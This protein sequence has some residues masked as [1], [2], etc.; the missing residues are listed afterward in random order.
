MKKFISYLTAII[1]VLQIISGISVFASG[2]TVKSAIVY[3]N[4]ATV[5]L[6]AE[7]GMNFNVYAASYNDDGMLTA[8]TYEN[9]TMTESTKTVTLDNVEDNVKI[10]VWDEN[11]AP[12]CKTAKSE[13]LNGIIYLNNTSI[14]ADGVTGATVDGTTVTITEAGN[15]KIVGTLDDG[16]IVISSSAKSDKIKL[17]LDN[18]SVTSTTGNALN[19]LKGKVTIVNSGESTFTAQADSTDAIYSKNDLTVKGEGTLNAVSELGNGIRCKADLEIGSGDINVTAYNNGIKGDEGIKITK[20]ASEI[21]VTAQTGDALK[22]DA[23]DPD[24]LELEYGKGNITINGGTLN[25]TATAGDGI[26]A[27]DTVTIAGGDITINSA[28]DGIKANTV[29]TP[30]TDETGTT[31]YVEGNVFINGGTVDITASEDGI[32]ASGSVNISDGDI[33]VVSMLDGIQSGV[34]YT[35]A[36]NETQYSQGDL[37]ISGGTLDI[38]AGGGSGANRNDDLSH[39]GV[40]ALNE[41]VIT[42]GTFDINSYDDAIHSNMITTIA[43]GTFEISSGDDGIHADYKLN[44]GTEG[45]ADDD[46]YVNITTSYEGLEGS[47]INILSGT[48]CMYS[49]DDGVNAAGDY[50]EDG[51]VTSTSSGSSG[52]GGQQPGGP[53]GGGRPGMGGG[54][55]GF[56]GGPGGGM[57]DSA[58]NGVLYING[59]MLYMVANG[60]GLDS[61]GNI[62]MSGGVVVVNGT[63]RGGNG[64]FDKGDNNNTF[65]VTGGTL[66]GFGTR[67]MLDNPSTVSGQGYYS[68]TSTS[69]SKGSVLK[70]ATDSGYIA[71]IPEIT[72]SGGML[73]VTCPEM[74]SGK[75]YSKLSDTSVSGATQVLG[76]TVNG[77]WYGLLQK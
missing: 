34:D 54:P 39:K 40:K 30:T 63:T 17:Y 68:N 44:M 32:K 36:N 43:G 69:I 61:N 22:S 53:G 45:G 35:D 3:G 25:L 14:N 74:T 2:V 18:V 29:N 19:A 10:F 1:I 62:A 72:I 11:I 64:V 33:T 27:D 12:L 56:N 55:G 8:I 48:T 57:E 7:V 20:N 59:G 26:Q 51:N 6:S 73:Y 37:T 46:F 41:L 77:T 76:R 24:T 52:Q 16:Q 38:T 28:A 49:T 71:V 66:I 67:D 58:A 13:E 50:D 70:V 42:G 65:T 9:V 60:D 75:T 23:I 21:T 47:V 31:I 5:E 4:T 15:Y